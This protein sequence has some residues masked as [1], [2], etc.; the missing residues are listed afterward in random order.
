MTIVKFG[1]IVG[2]MAKDLFTVT[3][4]AKLLKVTRQGIHNAI[5]RGRLI[6]SR[7]GSVLLI[8]R[9]ALE[10]YTKSRKRTGRPP[11]KKTR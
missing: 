9:S 4:A 2:L 5:T 7:V 8:R 3:Q 6:A 10:R 11:H 1:P